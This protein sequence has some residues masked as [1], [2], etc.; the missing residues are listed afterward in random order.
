MSE[1]RY[2]SERQSGEQARD[3]DEVDEPFWRAFVGLINSYLAGNWFTQSFPET[4]FESPHPI[5]CDTQSLSSVFRAEIPEVGWPLAPDSQPGTLAVLDAVEFF[6]RIVSKPTETR[7]HSYGDHHHI[8]RFDRDEGFIEYRDTVNRLLRRCRHPFEL[9]D[10]L[11]G[12]VERIPPEGLDEL[13]RPKFSTGD[14]TLN[15]LLETALTKIR[16]PNPACR[17]EA[18]EKLW[19]AFERLKTLLSPDKKEGASNLIEKAF[20]EP[21]LRKH[22]EV[23]ARELTHI[24]NNFLIRHTETTKVPISEP[25]HVYYLFHRLLALINVLIT[26]G[27]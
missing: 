22:V 26:G 8:L 12:K 27:A 24:G 13:V 25:D 6:A 14:P 9:I 21:N 5:E 23:E 11:D 2:F 7:Y 3:R 18:L 16:D 15:G 17:A 4:C 1:H 10:Y 20:P 19:D